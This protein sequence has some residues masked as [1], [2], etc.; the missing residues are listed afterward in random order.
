[1]ISVESYIKGVNSIYNE[2]P[3]YELGHD[4]SDGKCDCIG[5]CR[6]ALKRAGVNPTGMGGTNF[7]AR[8]TVKDLHKIKSA[9]ELC[10][11]DV[12]FKT[13][14][15]DDSS[16]PLPDRYRKGGK[17]Y[18]G[19]LTNYT[20]IGTVTKENPLEITHMTSPTAKKDT[21]LG[22]WEYAA[23]LPWVET[24]T[25]AE[26]PPEVFPDDEPQT[27]IV[28]AASGKTVKMRARPSTS[29]K[30]YWDVPIGTTVIV[31]QWGDDWSQI[32][33]NATMGYMMTKFLSI[34]E[35]SDLYT[36]IIPHLS[37]S[38]ADALVTQYPGTAMTLERG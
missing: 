14:S 1:M 21:K 5:M 10:V 33:Y 31:D 24:N 17:D 20:H 3:V 19:D 26:P 25:P 22:K 11:G 36:V 6:G 32:T 35:S 16:M 37:K 8:F 18:T 29:C 4:G 13:R 27:A 30:L 9:S 28:T 15:A 23:T 2:K 7:A 38:Q 12:V 34:P